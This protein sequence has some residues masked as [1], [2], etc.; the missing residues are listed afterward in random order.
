MAVA[1]STS[2]ASV[3]RSSS[4]GSEADAA[5]ED[6]AKTSQERH[7]PPREGGVLFGGWGKRFAGAN[8][9]R[10]GSWLALKWVARVRRGTRKA[11]I[12]RRISSAQEM[13]SSR[14]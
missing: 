8:Q 11:W 1:T 12:N 6:I 7:P 3:W 14:E 13:R 9:H 10:R 5:A 2:A 4:K